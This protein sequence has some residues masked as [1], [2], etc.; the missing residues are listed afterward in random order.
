MPKSA[1]IYYKSEENKHAF[2]QTEKDY[3]VNET[4]MRG[5]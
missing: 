2:T 5:N 4:K 3:T 1:C